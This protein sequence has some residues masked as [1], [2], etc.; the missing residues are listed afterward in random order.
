[1]W[2][3]IDRR[4][5]WAT[6]PFIRSL[7][8]LAN[9]HQ[10]GVQLVGEGVWFV[11]KMQTL[12][13]YSPFRATIP[14]QVPF[15]ET[16]IQFHDE[17][18]GALAPGRVFTFELSPAE[19]PPRGVEH[20]HVGKQPIP[21][22]ALTLARQAASWAASRGHQRSLCHRRGVSHFFRP[23]DTARASGHTKV[24]SGS[25][26]GGADYPFHLGSAKTKRLDIGNAGHS[27]GADRM[28]QPIGYEECQG[29][30]TWIQTGEF[31]AWGN[32]TVSDSEWT[33]GA[34]VSTQPWSS[35]VSH[36]EC[37]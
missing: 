13:T 4:V 1:L 2:A 25:T 6:R 24:V 8:T 22:T 5:A 10:R 18:P 16:E 26:P 17:K 19:S 37:H 15:G 30:D 34:R 31:D 35:S 21:T 23:I 33:K 27:H 36:S 20:N 9:Q 29:K 28:V 32:W 11:F 14:N 7:H 12:S 3:T